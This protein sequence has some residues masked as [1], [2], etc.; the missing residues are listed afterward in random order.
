M[1]FGI[2]RLSSLTYEFFEPQKPSPGTDARKLKYPSETPYV[3]RPLIG[4]DILVVSAGQA[5][6]FVSLQRGYK[7][8]MAA[9]LRTIPGAVPDASALG[10][11]EELLNMGSAAQGLLLVV[12][13]T[14]SGKST[15]LA[16]LIDRINRTR[17][18]RIIT[19]EDPVEMMF[20]DEQCVIEQREVG[21]DT[22]SF[23]RAL[24][25]ALRE[26][27]DLV[28]VGEM[29]DAISIGAAMRAAAR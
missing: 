3:Y 26:D 25:S 9:A 8:R 10:L 23:N 13:P 21:L 2:G 15:T 6:N 14:G 5:K 4:E 24:K 17:K 20:E 12:G 18:C 1:S 11:P 19:I 29:R 16:C 28:L 7:G 22:M 27:P